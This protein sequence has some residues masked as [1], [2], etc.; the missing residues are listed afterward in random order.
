MDDTDGPF[1]QSGI[2]RF[3]W[4]WFSGF[5]ANLLVFFWVWATFQAAGIGVLVTFNCWVAL[6]LV[7]GLYPALFLLLLGFF[8]KKA[9]LPLVGGM[10]W[11]GLD[12]VKETIL[13]GF[14]WALLSHTQIEF[15]HLI[16]IA[17][18]ATAHAVTFLLIAVNISLALGVRVWVGSYFSRDRFTMMRVA[19][20]LWVIPV[21]LIC[22]AC[23][24][25]RL[26]KTREIG[27]PVRIAILQGNINQYQK[28][29][30]AHET[31]IKMRYESLVEKAAEKGV[32]L[33]VWPESAVPGWIPN[34]KP[35]MDWLTTLIQRSNTYHIIGAVS[36]RGGKEFNS[37]FFFGPDGKIIDVYD[38]RH[39]V[40]FGEYIPFG[41]FLKRLVPYLGELG[42]F[43]SGDTARIF[44]L[45]IQGSNGFV[46]IE[47]NICYESIFP[48][49]TKADFVV[50]ITNDAWYLKTGAPAQHY[51]ANVYRAIENNLPVVR[52]ANT[53]ISA[54]IDPYGKALFKSRLMEDGVFFETVY[55]SSGS[56]HL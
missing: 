50:N 13:T 17:S 25:Q 12:I 29:D 32:D 10:L 27:S 52:A 20:N 49:R 55:S 41:C 1:F 16:Q 46:R 30:A 44:L 34:E 54:V 47:P 45:P 26:K 33:V 40:P 6:A 21:V 2:N 3:L 9:F 43:D 4:G 51:A 48:F 5:V 39:L 18:F 19:K 42:T 15:L 7:M 24:H 8:P 14:P 53:G 35:V 31:F 38:K 11:I 22:L 37:A 56:D 28:W 23:G 36:E